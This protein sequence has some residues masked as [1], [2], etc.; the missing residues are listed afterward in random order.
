[1]IELTEVILLAC[2]GLAGGILAGML[3][4]GGGMIYILV[5][6]IFLRKLSATPIA[7]VDL[8]QLMIANS[9]FALVFAG[10]AGSI[11]QSTSKNFYW[12]PVLI[13]GIGGVV[14]SLSLKV[15]MQL[16]GFYSTT[17]FAIFFTILMIPVFIR[18]FMK[19]RNGD[20][21]LVPQLKRTELL[22]T[23]MASGAISALS[24]LGG[25]FIMIP[26][27]N[28]LLRVP[29]KQTISISLGVIAF[30]AIGYSIYNLFFTSYPQYAFQY[31]LGSIVFPMVLPVVAG[32]M[33]GAPLGVKWSH[34]LPPGLLKILFALF[35][36][37]VVV[38]LLTDFL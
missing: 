30:V 33:A 37:A 25:G 20:D 10:I 22:L 35:C 31:S 4:I 14:S 29:I 17:E 36:I 34:K 1:M 18:M 5:F 27:L 2:T 23:G 6:S 32:V 12:K 8:V 26:V 24:G 15:I 11:R 21:K 3:G 28:G 38:K 9:I 16:T 19:H 7:G 13:I